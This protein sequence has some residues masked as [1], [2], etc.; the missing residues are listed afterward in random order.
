MSK[1]STVLTTFTNEAALIAAL[2]TLFG[3][4]AVEVHAGAGANLYGYQGDKRAT[5]AN[6]IVRRQHV[7]QLSNDLGWKWNEAAGVF[8]SQISQYDQ[9][10]ARG[11]IEQLAQN[12]GAEVI[13]ITAAEMGLTLGAIVMN[14][15]GTMTV[16]ADI[17]EF[18]YNYLS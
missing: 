14:A 15:D 5:M 6:L 7:G 12:Y 8:E 16:T 2:R 1:Y 18:Q 3:D 11:K 4:N 10:H 17:P 13:K 9:G